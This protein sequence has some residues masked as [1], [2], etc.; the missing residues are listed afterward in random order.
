MEVERIYKN[1]NIQLR[2]QITFTCKIEDHI[3]LENIT[4][5]SLSSVRIELSVPS[6][7]QI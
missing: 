7:Y 1:N 6:I 3:S 2:K 4:S 5:V